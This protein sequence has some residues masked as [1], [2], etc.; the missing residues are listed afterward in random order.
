MF[1]QWINIAAIQPSKSEEGEEA[2]VG[3]NPSHNE[4]AKTRLCLR[5]PGYLT[6]ILAFGYRY[7]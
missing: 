6:D 2:G 3:K 5:L 1:G 7:R 4:R